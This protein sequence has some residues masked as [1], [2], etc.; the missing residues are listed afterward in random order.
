MRS[1]DLGV[2]SDGEGGPASCLLRESQSR[3]AQR[4]SGHQELNGAAIAS[5]IT[6]LMPPHSYVMLTVFHTCSLLSSS[7]HCDTSPS[8]YLRLMSER[9]AAKEVRQA[10]QS[11]SGLGFQELQG[12][13]R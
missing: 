4:C 12:L 8:F 9:T 13:S 2:G 6:L 5:L 1:V 7:L 11:L 10:A 3:Q